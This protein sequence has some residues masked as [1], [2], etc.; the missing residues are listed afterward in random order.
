MKLIPLSQG[1]FAKVDDEDYDGLSKHRWYLACKTYAAR[2]KKV[3]K[4]RI[5]ILMHRELIKV[6]SKMQIDH[7]NGD[8]L[9]NRK[10]N[11]RICTKAQNAKNSKGR[12]HHTSSKFKGVA[13][14]TEADGFRCSIVLNRKK[15]Y[16]GSFRTEEAAAL[17]YNEAAIKYHGEFARLNEI[18][19]AA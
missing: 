17:A 18:G 11:L 7:I 16:L 15:I 14:H 1:A 12:K 8:G 19:G 9:D 4:K 3:R 2:N 13:K 5:T 6:N 10:A